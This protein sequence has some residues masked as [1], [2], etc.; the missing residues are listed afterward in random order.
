MIHATAVARVERPLRNRDRLNEARAA[1]RA[2][3]RLHSNQG[4]ADVAFR[5]IRNTDSDAD[6]MG[7]AHN[8]RI[9]RLCWGRPVS[10]CSRLL[11]VWN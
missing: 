3:P 11:S 2:S 10:L 5:G 6:P 7:A 8:L 9:L 4:W 1:P